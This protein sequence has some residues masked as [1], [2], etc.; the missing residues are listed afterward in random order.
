M[1][2][3]NSTAADQKGYDVFLNYAAVIIFPFSIIVLEAVLFHLLMIVSNYLQATTVISIAL[4]GIAFGALVSFYLLRYSKAFVVN[5]S[6]IIFILSIGMSYYSIVRLDNFNFPWLLIFPFFSGSIIVSAVFSRADSHRVY[7]TDLTASALGVIFPIIT[8]F[9]IKSENTLLVLSILPMVYIFMQLFTVRNRGVMVFGQ[10]I[11]FISAV[12]IILFIVM[13]ITVPLAINSHDFEKK[14]LPSLTKEIEKNIITGAYSKSSDG[15]RYLLDTTDPDKIMMA[16]NVLTGTDYYPFVMDLNRNYK[17]SFSAEKNYK[18]YTDKLSDYTFLYS[19]DSLIGRVEFITK[20]DFDYYYINNGSFFDRVIFRDRGSKYDI[21]FPNYIK[22]AKVFIV[23]ASAD[24]IVKSLK[25]LP[26]KPEISGVEFNPIIHEIMSSGYFFQKSER[27]YLNTEI[28]RT[29]GRAYLRSSEEKFDM[30]T[31]MNN[32][33]EH[34]AICT[35]A[36]EY[37]HT[38]EAVQ[39]MLSSL[40]DRGIL[41]YEEILWSTRAHWFF[42]KFINTIVYALKDMGIEKP[43]DHILVYQ[44]D[45]WNYSRPAV[46]SVVIKRSAFTPGEKELLNENLVYYL[47]NKKLPLMSSRQPILAYPGIILPGKVGDIISGESIDNY[48]LPDYYWTD[49]FERDVLS[50]IKKQEDRDFINSLYHIYPSEENTNGFDFVNTVHNFRQ[51]RYVLKPGILSEDEARYRELLEKTDYSY[52]MDI[53]PITDDQPFPYNVFVEKKE[54][55]KILKI[56]GMLSL[57][58]FLPVLFLIIKKYKSYKFKLF[59]HTL[60]FIS[61]GFGFM[62]VEIVLMQ[63]FQRFIGV[64]V[65]SV[66]ITLG[67]LLFFSGIGSIVSSK[68]NYTGVKIAVFLIPPVLYLYQKYLDS[69][70]QFF[71]P[72]TFETRLY[73]SVIIMIPVSFLMGVPFPGAMERIKKDITR[74]YATLMYA[75]SGAA[76]T[77]AA[78][79]AIYFNA[80]CGF[81]FTFYIGMAS[82]ASG[83]FLLLFILR[84]K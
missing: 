46:R 84:K 45:Y 24:G 10:I 66:I 52:K 19:R 55:I 39:E 51:G 42:Y 9:Y 12:L 47:S 81:L 64:P 63:F 78:A 30:I 14:V 79:A 27:A 69:V 65:Y 20:T 73:I 54:I 21:R 40:T 76:G 31:H 2:N 41:V 50:K 67:G 25:R 56:L 61:V 68:W 13:N 70:F 33:A 6:A 58:I 17:P 71:A 32:H 38:V 28:Y 29:E 23:G 34:G 59:N 37:L 60:F 15:S 82:Y 5:I 1:N 3:Q 16:K 18:I 53:S 75:I 35:I 49:D 72:F 4:F 43:E 36:P 77:I 8:V 83:A 48:Q 7:F 11:T 44:W 57:L 26:G 74:E 80:A 62:L 22:D